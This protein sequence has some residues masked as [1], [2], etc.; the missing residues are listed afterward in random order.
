MTPIRRI[1][2]SK[3]NSSPTHKP[4]TKETSTAVQVGRRWHYLSIPWRRIDLGVCR[5]PAARVDRAG[6]QYGR[7]R[8][9]CHGGQAAIGAG[10]R[11]PT[12][13]G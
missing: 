11:E 13:T 10:V 9:P 6:Q 8:W 1:E 3:V 2:R 5:D 4:D 7:G 12:D